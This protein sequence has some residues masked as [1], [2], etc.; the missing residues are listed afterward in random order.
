MI[1]DSHDA[2]CN[3]TMGT[4]SVISDMLNRLQKCFYLSTVKLTNFK[5]LPNPTELNTSSSW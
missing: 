1:S 2:M 4:S 5:R 3:Y